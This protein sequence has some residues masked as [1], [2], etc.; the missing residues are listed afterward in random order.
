MFAPVLIHIL[1]SVAP[2]WITSIFRSISYPVWFDSVV[3]F[4]LGGE[5]GLSVD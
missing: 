5:Y 2:F 4:V 3:A 1:G